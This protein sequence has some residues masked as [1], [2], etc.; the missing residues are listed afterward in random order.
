M[1]AWRFPFQALPSRLE[2]LDRLGRRG[3]CRDVFGEEVVRVEADE[4]I[5]FVARNETG[6][7][8]VC[9]GRCAP[10]GPGGEGEKAEG[11]EKAVGGRAFTCLL[12]AALLVAG[13]VVISEGDARGIRGDVR[14]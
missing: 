12:G 5:E 8:V 4:G 9:E 13:A 7:G 10:C 14:C 6:A 1:Y 11:M 3:R 2:Y